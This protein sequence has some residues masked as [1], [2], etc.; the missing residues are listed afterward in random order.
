MEHCSKVLCLN[1]SPVLDWRESKAKSLI[2]EL[3]LTSVFPFASVA[4][5]LYSWMLPTG[6]IEICSPQGPWPAVVVYQAWKAS[7]F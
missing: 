7:A 4:P 5:S 6:T 1:R 3:L 2:S